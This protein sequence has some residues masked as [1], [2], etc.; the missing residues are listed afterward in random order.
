MTVRSLLEAAI[1]GAADHS[2]TDANGALL[3]EHVHLVDEA[4]VQATRPALMNVVN[5]EDAQGTHMVLTACRKWLKTC[6]DT[7]AERRDAL[8]KK[9]L[10]SEADMDKGCTLFHICNSLVLSK[11]LM[12]ISTTPKGELEGVLAFLVPSSQCITI[13]NNVHRDADH[14]GQ[15]RTL[16]MAQ[17]CFW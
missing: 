6:K 12:Y 5:W 11:G 14:Q 13:L 4:R 10:G 8:L 17:E 3:H 1:I 9:Y 7:L 2:D 16:V 15:L